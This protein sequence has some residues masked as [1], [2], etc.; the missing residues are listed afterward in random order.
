[1]VARNYQPSRTD[2]GTGTDSN[3]N[4][5]TTTHHVSE[6]FTVYVATDHWSG[7]VEVHAAEYANL[8]EG[9]PATVFVY[10]GRLTGWVNKRV[11]IH[12]TEH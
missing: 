1:V 9:D 10:R 4:L 2:Y 6:K 8:K 3:G 5:V 11:V 7:P 12:Q